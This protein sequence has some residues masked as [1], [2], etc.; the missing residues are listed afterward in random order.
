[1]PL[2][3]RSRAVLDALLPATSDPTLPLG[4]FEAGFDDFLADF[5]KTASPSMRL[6]FKAALWTA[7]W[8]APALIGKAPPISLYDR[9]TRERIL[10]AM[11]RSSLYSMRQM[12]L[13][14]KAVSSFCYGAHPEVRKAVGFPRQFDEPS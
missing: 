6:G 8:A 12:L 3:P 10:E 7:A 9:P 4:L 1:M 5:E 11:G 13:L 14:L 2:N